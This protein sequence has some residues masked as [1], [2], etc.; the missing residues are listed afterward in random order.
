MSEP[1]PP[2]KW[3]TD[4]AAAIEELNAK[5]FVSAMGGRAFV[6]DTRYDQE[7]GRECLT[8]SR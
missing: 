6:C 5:Y 4:L 8:F 3:K 2:P 1:E 7:L